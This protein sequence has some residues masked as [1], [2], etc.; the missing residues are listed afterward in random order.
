MS[1]AKGVASEERTAREIART[2]TAIRK[3]YKAL[4]TGAVEDEIALEKRFK[5]IVEPLKRIAR[6]RERDN[7][8]ENESV[9]KVERD[10]DDTFTLKRP[11][12]R[13]KRLNATTIDSP[14]ISST[15]I[16]SQKFALSDMRGDE[17]EAREE[18]EDEVFETSDPSLGASVRQTLS[19]QQGIDM[20]HSQLG[21]LGRKYVGALLSGEKKTENDH[22]Y[23]VYLG[24]SG[25]MLGDKRFDVESD[26]SMIIDGIKYKGTPGLYELIFKRFPDDAIYNDNDQR[27]YKSILLNT[28]AHRRSHNALM[29][30]MGNKGYKYKHIIAPLVA[31]ERKKGA[32]VPPAMKVTNDNVEYVHWDDP[33]ELVDRLR[34]L[35]SSSRAGNHA[36]DNEML[37]IIEELR[38][39]GLIIN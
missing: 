31:G 38:E 8:S 18:E 32:G 29:P 39:A 7:I 30:I 36:H 9:V 22:V 3:K 24:E 17:E 5:P 27:T 13:A 12:K 4:K 34:L 19:T 14:M 21:R 6:Y 11:I 26:D 33:N 15:P 20:L 35:D 2:R 37:S 25:T 23:G 1:E 16:A 28:N 10:D